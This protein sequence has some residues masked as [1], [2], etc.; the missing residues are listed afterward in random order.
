[1]PN[2]LWEE[3]VDDPSK[4][5]R[6]A[7]TISAGSVVAVPVDAAAEAVAA[8]EVAVVLLEAATDLESLGDMLVGLERATCGLFL[9]DRPTLR[10]RSALCIIALPSLYFFWR[11][12]CCYSIIGFAGGSL[13]HGA[14][15][16]GGNCFAG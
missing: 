6:R 9:V 13:Q 15:L 14:C 5:P 10:C 2:T 16:S 4:T 11:W 3:A 1:M 12:S 7:P 8:E